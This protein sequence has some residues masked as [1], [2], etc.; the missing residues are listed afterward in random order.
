MRYL[1]LSESNYYFGASQHRQRKYL[2]S[3]NK[4]KQNNRFT[5]FSF[6]IKIW[7]FCRSTKQCSTA[8][9]DLLSTSVMRKAVVGDFA[10]DRI[11]KKRTTVGNYLICTP[12]NRDYRSHA[13]MMMSTSIS[14]DQLFL[15]TLR[16]PRTDIDSIRNKRNPF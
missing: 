3:K 2:P 14:G 6:G 1:G 12:K 9:A 13:F 5:R 16:I 8:P 4:T 15:E 11:F 10:E 7:A